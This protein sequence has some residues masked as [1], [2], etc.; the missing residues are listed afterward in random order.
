MTKPTPLKQHG[1]FSSRDTLEEALEYSQSL[2]SSRIP[3]K[4]RM[5]A[6]T[7]LFVSTNTA[8]GL[9]EKKNP[10][11]LTRMSKEEYKIFAEKY[12]SDSRG[13]YKSTDLSTEDTYKMLRTRLPEIILLV[14][15]LDKMGLPFTDDIGAYLLLL[16]NIFNISLDELAT[17]TAEVKHAIANYVPR[18]G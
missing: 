6:L 10:A 12:E 7:A 14:T 8:I 18:K 3:E 15:I 17:E 9:M 1:L 4:Y 13:R 2:I 5:E 16:A 11:N